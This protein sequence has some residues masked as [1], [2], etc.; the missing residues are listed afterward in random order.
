[1]NTPIDLSSESLLDSD[2]VEIISLNSKD[3]FLLMWDSKKSEPVSFPDF[4]I[5][6]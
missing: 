2:I 3:K 4:G 6:Q 5:Y 1:M